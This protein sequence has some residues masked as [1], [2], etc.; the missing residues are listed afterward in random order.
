MTEHDHKK[1]PAALPPRPAPAQDE[2]PIAAPPIARAALRTP[3]QP[4]D[5]ATRELMEPRF[6]RDFGDVRVHADARAAE[7]AEAVHALAYTAGQDV[8]RDGQIKVG[9]RV[10]DRIEQ[11]VIEILLR[12]CRGLGGQHHA[13]VTSSLDLPDVGEHAV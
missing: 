12:P 7:A 2:R 8:Q 1:K 4:L 5:A 9:D 13:N 10:L 11:G 6:G 3:G